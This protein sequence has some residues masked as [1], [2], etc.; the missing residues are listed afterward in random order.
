MVYLYHL[1]SPCHV[2]KCECLPLPPIW[3]SV[4]RL[5]L[6]LPSF[7]ILGS[8]LVLDPPPPLPAEIPAERCCV[9]DFFLPCTVCGMILGKPQPLRH[10]E[11]AYPLIHHE[12]LPF[13]D[14]SY[15]KRQ[16]FKP[17]TRGQT[18]TKKASVKL[19][20]STARN[21][22]DHR[23][24]SP[25]GTTVSTEHAHPWE[26]PCPLNSAHLAG[27]PYLQVTP[28]HVAESAV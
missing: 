5:S 2:S 22:R 16:C 8:F 14:I 26:P 12:K 10:G 1:T 11:S 21:H 19:L 13:A 3:E 28:A 15:Q 27:G 18:T 23:T 4:C 24:C 6:G 9:F 20:L 17:A 25:M 7:C